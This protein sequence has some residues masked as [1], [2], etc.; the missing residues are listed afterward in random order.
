MSSK[1]YD[2]VIFRYIIV[3]F[4]SMQFLIR[5][6]FIKLLKFKLVQSYTLN[7]YYEV[8]RPVTGLRAL[9]LIHDNAPAYKCVLV[10]DFLK[11]EK[12]VHLSHPPYSPVPATFS[13]FL[14]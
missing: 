4:N 13:C 9:C 2:K 8:R 6:A 1:L 10:Q 12:V 5:G 14:F 11:E 3:L 7:P